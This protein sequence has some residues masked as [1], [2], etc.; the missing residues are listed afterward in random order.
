MKEKI[1]AVLIEK[2]PEYPKIVLE[3]LDLPGTFDEIL[4]M[5]NCPSVYHRYLI[6]QKAQN[7]IIYV[8]DSDCMVNAFHLFKFYNGQITNAMPKEFIAKYKDTGITLLGWGAFFD[9]KM[10]TCFDPY[11]AKYGENDPHLLREADRIF[12]YLNQ[13]HNVVEMPHEDLFQT[14][15]RMGYQPDHYKSAQEALGKVKS[16]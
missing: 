4:I 7:S 8:Q 11:V 14:P 9:K 16:L 10:L 5:E 2:G 1:T 6:A 3:R 15:D 12:A 13:P